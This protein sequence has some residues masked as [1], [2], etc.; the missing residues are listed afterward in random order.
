MAKRIVGCVR[1]PRALV[2]KELHMRKL[3]FVMLLLVTLMALPA[4]AAPGAVE[5]DGP[6]TGTL[7]NVVVPEGADCRLQDASVNGNVW[8]K[9]TGGLVVEGSTING[10]VRGSGGRYWGFAD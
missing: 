7:P 4:A 3:H 9:A 10:N 6:R 1:A 2:G 5:C 8:G